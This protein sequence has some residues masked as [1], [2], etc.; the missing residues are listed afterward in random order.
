MQYEFLINLITLSYNIWLSN[1]QDIISKPSK[2]LSMV[3]TEKNEQKI[4]PFTVLQL[5]VFFHPWKF[6]KII[7]VKRWR[8]QPHLS[9]WR[10]LVFLRPQPNLWNRKALPF[11]H[12]TTHLL[13]F[14]WWILRL[15][16]LRFQ[17]QLPIVAKR[18]FK[19]RVT[20]YILILTH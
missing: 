11:S 19:L 3:R 8:R 16:L 20:E 12:N 9:I 5:L 10:E 17:T 7:D 14:R 6:W 13:L 4:L 2:N 1:P 15:F 18:Y